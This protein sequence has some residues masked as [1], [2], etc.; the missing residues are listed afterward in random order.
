MASLI[1]SGVISL[2][3]CACAGT[4]RTDASHKAWIIL[5]IGSLLWIDDRVGKHDRS[6][7]PM[8]PSESRRA[9]SGYAIRADS[10]PR[11]LEPERCLSQADPFTLS[12]GAPRC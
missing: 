3:T 11:L 2:T 9:G 6:M 7:P 4:T 10:S 8:P 5:R 1:R 12:G